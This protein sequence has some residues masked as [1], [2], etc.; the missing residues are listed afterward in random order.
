[1]SA[2][3]FVSKRYYVRPIHD[4]VLKKISIIKDISASDMV[5]EGLD[6]LM[7]SPKYKQ[8]INSNKHLF[9]NL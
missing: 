8:I 2:K 6:N 9:K 1:M 5:R 4:T 7:E 3:N